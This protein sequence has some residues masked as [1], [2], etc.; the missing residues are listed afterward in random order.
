[1]A[2]VLPN[3]IAIDADSVLFAKAETTYGTE[4]K[5][6]TADQCLILTG[7]QI[8]Q[9]R[10]YLNDEQL[11]NTLS[12]L[13]Q[14]AGRFE[15]GS[16]QFG[17]YIKPSGALGTP[18]ECATLLKAALGRETITASTKVEY[19]LDRLIDTLPAL[20]M[21]FR[22]G[23]TVY[24]AIGSVCEQVTFPLKADN[25]QE[26]VGQ[27]QVQFRFAE[28]RW[29]GT[30]EMAAT[31]ATSATTLTVKDAKKFTLGGYI[32]IAAND[33][34]G[35]GYNITAINYGSNI[36]TISPGLT[37]GVAIDDLVAP[38]MPTGTSSGTIVHGRL[39]L[40]TRGATN[41]PVLSSTITLN[42]PLLLP[43]DE[44][45]GLD[46]PNRFLRSDKRDV[47]IA[48][49][50]L[51]DANTTSYLYESLQQTRG[52][53]TMPCGSVA[54]TRFKV[55]AKNVEVSPPQIGGQPQK[56]VTLNGKAFASA[57][58]DDEISLLFD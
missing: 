20:T 3:T 2:T 25:S 53:I 17:F 28:M 34:G 47:T 30:D 18:P 29:T 31:A 27:A 8:T 44:K 23:H 10:G 57:S 39:G 12:R 9:D 56:V 26:A 51:N 42:R 21:W 36:L 55:L 5:V 16:A 4:I 41:L 37:A 24:R 45:N 50:L 58:F 22:I 11:R 32:K 15:P 48:V 1:M 13:N 38:W 14:I 19:F 6:T 7:G 35:V 49:E 54:A 46:Y 33:N 43:T 40:A 52:D